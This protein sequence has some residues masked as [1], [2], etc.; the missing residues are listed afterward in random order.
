MSEFAWGSTHISY[1]VYLALFG[2]LD[3]EILICVPRDSP[4]PDGISKSL[5][6]AART[7][8]V[9]NADEIVENI[10]DK[11]LM[12]TVEILT[13]EEKT[14]KQVWMR[15]RG[16]GFGMEIAFAGRGWSV[17]IWFRFFLCRQ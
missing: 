5:L 11:L 7:A 1:K 17:F 14:Q 3:T 4:T 15:S 8:L 13:K 10:L 9:A 2:S 6:R 12:E 16:C